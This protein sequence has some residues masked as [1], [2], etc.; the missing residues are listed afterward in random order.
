M[1]SA[2]PIWKSYRNLWICPY[3]PTFILLGAVNIFAYFFFIG[4]GSTAKLMHAS[5]FQVSRLIIYTTYL[6]SLERLQKSN[7]SRGFRSFDFFLIGKNAFW[8]APLLWKLDTTL[9]CTFV[10]ILKQMGRSCMDYV[11]Y[12]RCR[13]T[14]I[15]LKLLMQKYI[16]SCIPSSILILLTFWFT[17]VDK[18]I[19]TYLHKTN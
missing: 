8:K 2:P 7:S 19:G 18:D 11:G 17:Y 12:F 15:P 13:H 6:D 14:L 1:V 3:I 4:L 5:K 16:Y 10:H 9:C